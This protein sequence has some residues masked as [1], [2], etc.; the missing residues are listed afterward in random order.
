MMKP[1]PGS[2][3]ELLFL[4]LKDGCC[5][6]MQYRSERSG[7]DSQGHYFKELLFLGTCYF[8]EENLFSLLPYAKSLRLS[9]LSQPYLTVTSFSVSFH[10]FIRF[11][12]LGSHTCMSLPQSYAQPWSLFLSPHSGEHLDGQDVI[13]TL[14]HSFI[15]LSVTK[16]LEDSG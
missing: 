7:T 10:S 16:C 13:L 12:V 5:P 8:C 3:G 11:A 15:S 9:S 4:P 2:L 14:E 6:P 1:E